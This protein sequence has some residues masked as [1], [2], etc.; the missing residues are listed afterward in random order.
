M[1]LIKRKRTVLS[2]SGAAVLLSVVQLMANLLVIR[3]ISPEQLGIWN[4]I[5]VFKS[6]AL[7]LN[8]GVTN[9]L[10]RELPFLLGRKHKRVAKRI[11]ESALLISIAASVLALCGL[12]LS[13][14]LVETSQM[15]WSLQVLGVVCALSFVNMY[16][17]TTFRTN[18][19]FLLFAQINM[20]LTAAELVTLL[21]PATYGYEGFLTR[22][23]L[24]ELIKLT[25]FLVFQP[26]PVLP[27]FSKFAFLFLV[28]TGIPLFISTYLSAITDTFKRVILRG[29]SSFEMVG[30]FAP[31]LAV[32]SLNNLL[33]RTLGQY[34]F[35]KLNH[36][37]GAGDSLR[38]LW[39]KSVKFAL[40]NAVLMVPVV[41]IGWF[42]IP[43]AVTLL[44]P[45]YTVGAR[46]AQI[47]LISG[48]LAPFGMLMNF[49]HS[50]KIWRWIYALVLLKL[51]VFF[52]LQWISVRIMPPLIGIA[53]GVLISEVIYA[54]TIICIGTW[55]VRR[56]V[57][58]AIVGKSS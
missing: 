21:L 11:A 22:L 47:A 34:I 26:F 14:F 18:Q 43:H 38:S 28:N 20:V 3:W 2:F 5:I 56:G 23:A 57:P 31:A 39:I 32:Y 29:A 33:P 45:E 16:Y 24:I 27:K 35:P 55:F 25:L 6:Y 12:T 50:L 54:L 36:G 10:N 42:A 37:L 4:T 53:F 7:F 15:R 58:N 49:F 48:L 1:R 9:G 52:V 30:L 40:A 44:F 46:A 19:A 13:S 8:F 51:I 41:A 17:G